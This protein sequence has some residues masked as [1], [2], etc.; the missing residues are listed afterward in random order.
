MEA[1]TAQRMSFQDDFSPKTRR[2]QMAAHYRPTPPELVRQGA[3]TNLRGRLP[4]AQRRRLRWGVRLHA[5][6]YPLTSMWWA[7]ETP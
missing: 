5:R 3:Q 1:G 7:L 4:A 6:R 2:K